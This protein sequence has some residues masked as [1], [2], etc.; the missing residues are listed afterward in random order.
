MSLGAA[1]A[2][3]VL[4]GVQGASLTKLDQLKEEA[5]QA[6]EDS[7]TK[8]ERAY[9]TEERIA[10]QKFT[11]EEKAKELSQQQGQFNTTTG[12]KE[13]EL[14]QDKTQFEAENKREEDRLGIMKSESA[15]NAA[16]RARQL[17]YQEKQLQATINSST[18]SAQLQRE[19][20]ELNK[21]AKI[22]VINAENKGKLE[23]AQQLE[24]T[25][26]KEL[27][28]LPSYKSANPPAQA[29][30]ELFTK[31]NGKIPEGLLKPQA[32]GSLGL[33]VEG[34]KKLEGV[35]PQE[36]GAVIDRMRGLKDFDNSDPAVQY[37]KA[38]EIALRGKNADL[39][40]LKGV[41]DIAD[42][43]VFEV[44]KMAR[45][46]EHLADI[47]EDY[48]ET[49]RGK[50]IAAMEVLAKIEESTKTAVTPRATSGVL[51]DLSVIARPVDSPPIPGRQAIEAIKAWVRPFRGDPMKFFEDD[52]EVTE[53]Q[54]RSAD[55]YK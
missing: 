37:F 36:V 1:L 24:E 14:T 31:I 20:V 8:A 2:Q 49:A 22:A 48:N 15:A 18:L 17:E 27:R 42:D 11:A 52:T 46:G 50:I 6:R 45:R 13:R 10:E 39:G 32:D 47:I 3:G 43:K 4:R 12:L 34:T 21:E 55:I 28:D 44:A 41:K 26:M 19:L 51:S 7:L 40:G 23:A 35:T 29:A 53:L 25:K 38:A 16:H 9:K 30:I 5:K 54:R 33:L